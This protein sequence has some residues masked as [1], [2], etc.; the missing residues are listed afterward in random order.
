MNKYLLSIGAL[1]G[2][3][4]DQGEEVNGRNETVNT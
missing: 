1:C 4:D 3:R 2:V